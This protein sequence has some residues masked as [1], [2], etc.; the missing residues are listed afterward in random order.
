MKIRSTSLAMAAMMSA[1]FLAAPI[2]V[3][4]KAPDMVQG[5]Y[6]QPF[7]EGEQVASKEKHYEL[8][9]ELKKADRSG[10]S[11]RSKRVKSRFSFSAS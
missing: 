4:A 7:A 6:A 2:N 1:G 8:K 11:F 3:L 10:L 5:V 9:W